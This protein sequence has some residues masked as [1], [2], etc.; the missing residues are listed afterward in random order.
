AMNW[1]KVSGVFFLYRHLLVPLALFALRWAR[2]LVNSKTRELLDDRS[3]PLPPLPRD[4]RGATAHADTRK[5]LLVHAASGEIE[6]A[7]PVLRAARREHPDWRLVFSYFSPSSKRLHHDLE[8]DLVC[9]L[10]WD[11]RKNVAAFLD[12]FAPAAVLIARTDVWPE[13]AYQCRQHG[14]PT[15]LFAATWAPGKKSS[16]LQRFAFDQLTA[17]ACVSETDQQTLKEHTTTPVIA[18]GDPRF[19]QALFRLRKPKPLTVH[20]EDDSDQRNDGP[21]RRKIIALG[22]TW[23]EDD[24]LWLQTLREFPHVRQSFRFIWVPHEPR[25]AKI[26]SLTAQ[27]KS[28]ELPADLYSRTRGWRSQFL[29]VD[30]VGVLAELYRW[31]DFA[32]VGGSMARKVHSVLEP[33][34]AGLPVL[35]GPCIANSREAL[36]FQKIFLPPDGRPA[37]TVV[38]SA[39]ELGQELGQAIAS[40]KFTPE[41]KDL[42][43]QE[44]N[45]RSHA[46]E[47]LM[48]LLSDLKVFLGSSSLDQERTK[49]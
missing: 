11:D 8:A 10:P 34:A 26:A 27:L 41:A 5:T 19:E 21:K 12:H 17:I 46:T 40:Y 1:R 14:I 15:I 35:V 2:P 32:F 42:L 25:P 49:P 22:S 13:F 47:N 23:D 16:V 6:Y 4:T 43:Q 30:Q 9:P 31:A 7:K 36:E 3:K 38:R 37:V 48:N 45:M 29:L 20:R 39:Q 18:L 24:R 44:V 33:L 28:L